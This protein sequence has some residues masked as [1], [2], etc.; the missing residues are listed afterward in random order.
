M[1]ARFAA[2]SL[3]AMIFSEMTTISTTRSGGNGTGGDDYEVTLALHG[4]IVALIG[5]VVTIVWALTG[6]GQFWPMWV[7]LGLLITLAV[8]ALGRQLVDTLEGRTRPIVFHTAVTIFFCVL[9]VVIWLMAGG[10]YFWPIWPIVG[11]GSILGV[12]ALIVH[13]D[14]LPTRERELTERVDELTRTRRGA[15]DVQAAEL[16]RIERDLHDG[17][18]ARLVALSMQLGRAEERLE[19]QPD[20]AE[21]VRRARGEAGAAIKELRDLARGI[22]PPVLADRGLVAAVESLGQRSAVPVAVDA[23]IERRLLPVV[24]TAAYFVVAEA[25]TNV[26]KHAPSASARVTLAERDGLLIVEIADDGPG[27][28][29]DFGPA[30]GS[31][32]LAGLRNRVEALDGHLRVTSPAGVGTAIRAELPCRDEETP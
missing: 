8:H 3:S 32:G 26:A 6:A 2:D 20:V 1:T 30:P 7:W 31:T 11:L 25:L 21:L 24:E 13:K 12:H 27:G 28:A 17:A 9:E 14:L 18:Q 19:D 23:K 4:T 5:G 16:R 29:A 10:G 15:L 22:A